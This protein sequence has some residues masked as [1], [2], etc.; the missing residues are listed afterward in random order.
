MT[1]PSRSPSAK[2]LYQQTHFFGACLV[3]SAVDDSLP[4]CPDIGIDFDSCSLDIFSPG[5]VAALSLAVSAGFVPVCGG[6]GIAGDVL[7]GASAGVLETGGTT[8]ACGGGDDG[9][10]PQATSAAAAVIAI[11]R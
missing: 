1:P 8:L 2:F 4:A 10:S 7:A 6:V 3:S 11:S 5:L 9:L